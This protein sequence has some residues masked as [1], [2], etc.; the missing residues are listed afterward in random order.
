MNKKLIPIASV[1]IGIIVLVGGFFF[2]QNSGKN[3]L[4]EEHTKYLMTI[5]ILMEVL[6]G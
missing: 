3:D 2:Y 5:M 1:I 4:K 6:K